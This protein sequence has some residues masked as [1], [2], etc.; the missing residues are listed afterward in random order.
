MPEF[1]S[2]L[3]LREILRY[4]TDRASPY[5]DYAWREFLGRYK[6]FI[7]DQVKRCCGA[8]RSDR[9]KLQLDETV[10]DIFAKIVTELCS[11]E[12][13]ALRE[14]RGCEGDEDHERMFRGWLKTICHHHSNRELKKLW[15]KVL[16]NKAP[17]ERENA[18]LELAQDV[19]WLLYDD[20]VST[21]RRHK[22]NKLLERDIHIFLL[23]TFGTFTEAMIR[24]PD[25][26][27][28]LGERVIQV[29]I[30]RMRARLREWKDLFF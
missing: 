9:L 21:L 3:T 23:S 14:F 5:Y 10:E 19:A 8:W 2:S 27:K 18:L 7:Y 11:H 16:G 20:V 12:F 25:F 17:E 29:V 24:V 26:M 28:A 6:K 22:A 30:N 15:W 4:C 13:K 1:S